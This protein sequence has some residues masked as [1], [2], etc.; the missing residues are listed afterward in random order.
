MIALLFTEYLLVRNHVVPQEHNLL[1]LGVLT[2]TFKLLLVPQ[3]LHFVS[4]CSAAAPPIHSESCCILALA[5]H[6]IAEPLHKNPAFWIPSDIVVWL[7]QDGNWH[8]LTLTTLTD[9]PGYGLFVDG[10]L[11]GA[12][13]SQTGLP[14]ST[15]C[16][17]ALHACL[18]RQRLVSIT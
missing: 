10:V 8:M 18:E 5:N 2:G 12:V 14:H 17:T 4:Q 15:G 6:Q 7:L 9:R 11:R 16:P 1:R 3:I 13:D